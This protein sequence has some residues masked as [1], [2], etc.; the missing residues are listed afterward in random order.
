M[1][2]LFAEAAFFHKAGMER[3]T[4]GDPRQVWRRKQLMVS[5][6]HSGHACSKLLGFPAWVSAE[7]RG[8]KLERIR[9]VMICVIGEGGKGF[10]GLVVRCGMIY[11]KE[12]QLCS[13]SIVCFTQSLL[14]V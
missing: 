8:V 2:D 12:I 13:L 11:S 3:R 14:L 6:S 9:Y 7:Q 1:T 10:L 4:T 5:Q